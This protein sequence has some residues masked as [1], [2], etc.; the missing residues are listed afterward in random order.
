MKAASFLVLVVGLAACGESVEQAN[1]PSSGGGG[2]ASG[3]AGAPAG[4][5][6]NGGA[7]NAGGAG[8][9]CSSTATDA[10]V[11]VTITFRNDRPAPIY[12]LSSEC[13][14][15]WHIVSPSGA[16]APRDWADMSCDYTV[17]ACPLDCLDDGSEELAPGAERT[18][19]WNGHLVEDIDAVANHCPYA[20][21][22]GEPGCFPS[23][24]RSVN[25]PAGLYQLAAYAW[26]MPLSGTSLT[27][28][29]SFDYPAT[30]DILVSFVP[31]DG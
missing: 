19:T 13:A 6:G 18:F 22:V 20:A 3:G 9:A 26:T 1:G 15:P 31:G 16:D 4:G 28:M 2:Q 12:L 29:M 14:Q 10:A 11:Q 21:L 24:Q 30:T 17:G 25:A 27:K 8:E 7:G 5:A 23:C